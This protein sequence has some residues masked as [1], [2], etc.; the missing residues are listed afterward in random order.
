MQKHERQCEGGAIERTQQM[1]STVAVDNALELVLLDLPEPCLALILS[2][3]TVPCV[4]CAR[5]ACQALRLLTAADAELVWSR[6]AEAWRW[7]LR[8]R[9][10]EWATSIVRRGYVGRRTQCLVAVGGCDEDDK[11]TRSCEALRL[12]EAE[13]AERLVR[14]RDGRTDAEVIAGGGVPGDAGRRLWRSAAPLSCARDAPAATSDGESVYVV[15]GWDGERGAFRAGRALRSC[16]M[17]SGRALLAEPDGTDEPGGSDGSSESS[18]E[19][20][21]E[22]EEEEEEEEGADQE[23]ASGGGGRWRRL[24]SLPEGRCFG[25]VHCDASRRLWVVGGGDTLLRGATCSSAIHVLALEGTAGGGGGGG[26][27]GHV[28]AGWQ[29]AGAMRRPRCGLA[30]ASDARR[31]TLYLVG[32]Y[33]GGTEYQDTVETFEPASGRGALL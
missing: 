28:V 12:A 13:E 7:R 14:T 25:A 6:M 17:A 31:D 23:E 22:G 9:D 33:S 8:R 2:W 10:D 11:A 16:A 15:G 3:C 27:G 19:E 5:R 18:G 30:M 26:G 4:G 20:A 1:A 24:P 32:G 21:D 29:A